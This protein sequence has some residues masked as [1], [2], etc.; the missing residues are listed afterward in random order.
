MINIGKK[1]IPLT[2]AFGQKKIQ[3]ISRLE[4]LEVVIGRGKQSWIEVG[5]ALTEVRD[6]ELY[7]ERYGSFNEY[8]ELRWGFKKRY[9]SYLIGSSTEAIKLPEDKRPKTEGAM[10]KLL[11]P[12]QK[13]GTFVPKMKAALKK[14]PAASAREIEA[15]I[16][17]PDL[18]DELVTRI[19]ANRHNGGFLKALAEWLDDSG[20]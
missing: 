16:I 8:C 2:A 19:Q 12:Q 11:I 13:T 10:R 17:E 14:N 4:E 18:C 3:P 1:T 7:K 9:A 6:K 20:L 15:E 5:E